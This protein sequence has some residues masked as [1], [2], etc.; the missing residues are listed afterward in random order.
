MALTK[1]SANYLLRLATDPTALANHRNNGPAS[2]TAFTL[3][4]SEQ[5]VIAGLEDVN[6]KISID[7]EDYNPFQQMH[8]GSVSL[9]I[10][11]R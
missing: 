7:A 6:V 10:K 2:M 9:N 3:N 5:L 4:A 11:V 8:H 1:K